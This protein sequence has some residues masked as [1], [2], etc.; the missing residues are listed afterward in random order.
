[1]MSKLFSVDLYIKIKENT[2]EAKKLTADGHWQSIVSQEPFTTQRLLV[3]SFSEAERALTQLLKRV[4]GQGIFA[5]KPKVV[6]HPMEKV[7]G[8][9]SQIEDRIFRELALGAGALKLVVDTGPELTDSQ[10]IKLIH[11]A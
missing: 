10:A 7:E 11:A 5:K 9:L 4:L 1:M 6:I 2:C 3:G 8:G